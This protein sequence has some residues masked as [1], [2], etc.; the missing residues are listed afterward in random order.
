MKNFNRFLSIILIITF[1]VGIYGCYPAPVNSTPKTVSGFKLNTYVSVTAYGNCDENILNECLSLCDKYEQIFSRTM[2]DSLL[3]KLNNNTLTQSDDDLYALIK[4][5]LLYSR[6][7]KG[8]FDITIGAVSQLWDFTV[9]NPKAPSD[10]EIQKMLPFVDYNSV[11]L[12]DETQKI[13]LP[14]GCVIDLGA[15]A[16]GY[17]ADKMKE[18]LLENG[19]DGAII[20]LGGNVLCVGK[21]PDDSAFKIAVK[22]PFTESDSVAVLKID[23]MSVVS[24]GTYE[25]Y[26]TENDHFYHHILNPQTGY[27]YDNGLSG[28]TIISKESLTGDALSTLCFSL[29]LT[30]GLDYI[31]SLPDV[32]AV[33]ITK[34]GAVY[35]SDGM[36]K[37]M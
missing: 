37:Y 8:S 30:A 35:Y 13:T 6:K 26:F 22:K 31:N 16:K 24:S 36:D 27:P 33:F 12:D 14:K 17:I 29:G 10:E 2:E 4:E 20:N 28:V 18:F 3:Y 15:I 7:S 25:R 32:E 9:Q 21:K 1:L 5:G 19:V 34:D 23:D 11:E